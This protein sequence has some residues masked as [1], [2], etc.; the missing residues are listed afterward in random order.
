MKVAIAGLQHETNTFLDTSTPLEAFD[1][2][3]AFG[4]WR[5]GGEILQMADRGHPVPITGFIGEARKRNWQLAP[6]H[7]AFAEPGGTV[8][9]DAYETMVGRILDALTAACPVDAVYLDLHGAMVAHG[10]PDG[11]GELLAR[12]RRLL[13]ADVPIV[14]SL[15]LHGNV[16]RAMVE[17]AT[18]LVA[19]RT[20]PHV[21][22]V[23]TGA[24]AAD[25]L[26]VVS[27]SKES[28]RTFLKLPFLIPIHRQTT[29]AEPCRTIYRRLEDIE[30]A[31][32][33]ISLSFLP[34]FPPADIVECGP[35]ILAYAE[36]EDV[37]RAAASELSDVIAGFERDFETSLPFAAEA[38]A[39]AMSWN[40]EK[41]ALI[42]DVQDNPGGGGTGDTVWL[43]E[44]LLLRDAQNAVLALLYDPESAARAHE[45]GVGTSGRF[46]LGGKSMA[47][48]SPLEHN[49]EV[50]ALTDRPVELTGP[51]TRGMS[52][53][54]GKSALL[55][56]GGVRVVVSSLR[57]QCHDQAYFRLF[58]IEPAEQ[59]IV[60]VK[61]TNHYRADFEPIVGVIIE[62]MCPGACVMDPVTLP[63]R[64]LRPG[65]RLSPGK[66]HGSTQ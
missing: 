8:E 58:G 40:G 60:V 36:D 12:M 50:E 51:M 55:R 30:A 44:E 15:D 63:Y 4:P 7:W 10:I 32:G 61:S 34:G 20:Y 26:A 56:S 37:A 28:A 9:A 3:S 31:H 53:N 39:Q 14:A 48:Q 17:H 11:E 29:F 25:L 5:S 46:L 59:R 22:F 41:P 24:R 54:L 65:V 57:T 23:E 45:L 6:L 35:A 19:Y 13:G 62:A 33:V 38:V 43:L 66:V 27:R 47:G 64:N 21:D 42:A 52:V 16:T 2:G 49:F 1:K 18:A